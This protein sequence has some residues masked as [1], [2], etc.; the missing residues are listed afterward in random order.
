MD[1]ALSFAARKET[2]QSRYGFA[3]DCSL[4]IFSQRHLSR[5]P[6]PP[7]RDSEELRSLE[8]ELRT[9]V[10]GN[11]TS[12]RQPPT[13]PEVFEGLPASLYPLL[14]EIYLPSIAEMFSNTSHDGPYDVALSTGQILLALYLVIYPPNYPQTGV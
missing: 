4:C 13:S 5:V 8:R 12:F 2:L 6:L 11:E 1:P 10:L 3:C 7:P 9:F 14:H